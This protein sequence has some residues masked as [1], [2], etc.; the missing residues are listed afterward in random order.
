M[1]IDQSNRGFTSGSQHAL[2]VALVIMAVS[3]I[4]TLF[5]LPA[6]IREPAAP[7]SEV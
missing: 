6:Q 4:L 2:A 1:I 7:D 5:I 3:A